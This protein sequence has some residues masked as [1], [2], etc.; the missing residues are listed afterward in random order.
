MKPQNEPRLYR[1]DYTGKQKMKKL[2]V[3]LFCAAVLLPNSS[4]A[5]QAL[6]NEHNSPSASAMFID[7][8]FIRPLGLAGTAVGAA[9]YVVTLPFTLLGGNAGEAGKKLVGEPGAYTFQRPLGR[10]HRCN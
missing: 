6:C 8:I 4:F 9:T 10:T 7:T 1:I 3:L 2:Y 5:A